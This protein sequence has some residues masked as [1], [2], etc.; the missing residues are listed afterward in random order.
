MSEFISDHIRI[1]LS[2]LAQKTL[3]NDCILFGASANCNLTYGT[4]I[5]RILENFDDDFVL[6]ENLI[7]LKYEESS[8]TIRLR[9]NVIDILGDVT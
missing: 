6:D 2:L 4:L 7:K 1:T 8:S 9:N 3:E 5:N